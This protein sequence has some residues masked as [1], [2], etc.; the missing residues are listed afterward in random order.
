MS[1]KDNREFERRVDGFFAKC[2]WVMLRTLVFLVF[3]YELGRFAIWLW[4]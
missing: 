1:G 2:E 4:R 3:A